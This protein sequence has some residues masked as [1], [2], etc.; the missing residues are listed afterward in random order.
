MNVEY[1]IQIKS[2]TVAHSTPDFS[3][4]AVTLSP[5]VKITNIPHTLKPFQSRV[6][7]SIFQST[8]ESPQYTDVEGC[9]N[10]GTLTVTILYGS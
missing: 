2:K 3:S 10:L 1:M 7:F 8:I 6:L 5:G 4:N 9:T